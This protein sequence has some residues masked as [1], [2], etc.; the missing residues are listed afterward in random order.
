M[1]IIY[2]GAGLFV[3]AMSYQDQM[4][5]GVLADPDALE[6]PFEL[7][8]GIANELAHLVVRAREELATPKAPRPAPDVEPVAKATVARSKRARATQP[9]S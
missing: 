3:G 4:D 9:A 6:D 5:V 1:G 8:D 2:D 7:A